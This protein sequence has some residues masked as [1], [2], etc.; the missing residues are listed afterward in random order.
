MYFD[1]HAHYDSEHFGADRDQVLSG[2][3]AKG[4]ELVLNPGCDLESSRF[5]VDLADRWPF[6]YAAVG[7]HPEN[8][9]GV[10]LRA[11]DEIRALARRPKVKAIGEIGLDYYWVKDE[12][13]RARTREFYHA[14]LS[15]AEELDLPAIVHDRDAHRDC[16]DIAR[17]HPNVRGVFHCYAGSVE[18]A[19]VLVQMGW[20]LSFTGNITFKKARRALEV[21]EWLPMEHIMLETDA[22]YMTPEPFRGRRCDSGYLCRMAETVA[23]LKGLSTEEVAHITTQN[24]RRF[25][26][27]PQEA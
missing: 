25:F 26:R 1:T 24:G 22:P 14:Q 4:V 3:E 23:Q 5:A 7:F 16:L 10:P 12:P 15:L 11:L 18:E 2:L 6:L 27:I 13:G 9:E 20:M 19:K 21:L 8:L 17:A